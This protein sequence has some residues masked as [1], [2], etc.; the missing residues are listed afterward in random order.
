VADIPGDVQTGLT[1]QG[2]TTTRA[3]YLDTLSG[4]VATS[5]AAFWAF[6]TRTLTQTASQIA[7]AISG[8][9]VTVHR[10]D[11]FS[12][13]LTVADYT[14]YSKLWLTVKKHAGLADTASTIQIVL[15]SPGAGTDGL[16]YLNGAS[17]TA[18]QGSLVA[19]STTSVTIAIDEVATAV[20]EVRSYKYDVQAMVGT[21]IH[22]IGQGTWTVEA[23]YTLATS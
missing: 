17:A 14:G 9:T 8:S 20:L 10:G 2:Y 19:A 4:L 18:A 13:T 6:A 22:T 23:D 7:T 5:A 16:L 21:D 15:S 1:A 11:S 12:G 3:G